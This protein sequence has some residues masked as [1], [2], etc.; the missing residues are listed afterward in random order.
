VAHR[1]GLQLPR[2]STADAQPAGRLATHI[3]LISVGPL[4]WN[5][6]APQPTGSE[7][8]ESLRE[9]I[10]LYGSAGYREVAPFNDE[11]FAHH[12]F[13]QRLTRAR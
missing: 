2:E 1:L 4:G 8:S 7:W 9:A 11:P 5:F 10:A 13:E 6:R 12:W 3:R